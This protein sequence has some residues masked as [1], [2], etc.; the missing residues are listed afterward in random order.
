MFLV[1]YIERK[2]AFSLRC[3]L[4][5]TTLKK[6]KLN[7]SKVRDSIEKIDVIKLGSLDLRF[8]LIFISVSPV[9]TKS[10]MGCLLHTLVSRFT[11]ALAPPPIISSYLLRPYGTAVNLF[12]QSQNFSLIGFILNAPSLSSTLKFYMKTFLPVFSFSI[13]AASF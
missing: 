7:W 6:G 13:P 5:G 12:I 8:T 3:S 9:H 10:N 11:P 4:W 1:V 2:A